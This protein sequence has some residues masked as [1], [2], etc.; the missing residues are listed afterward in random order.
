[1]SVT[2]KT[3][4]ASF[5]R[6]DGSVSQGAI[7]TGVA[8]LELLPDNLYNYFKNNGWSYTIVAGTMHAG[9]YNVTSMSSGSVI[10]AATY[11]DGR[12]QVYVNQNHLA[13]SLLHELG[14]VIDCELGCE[15]CSQEFDEIYQAEKRAYLNIPGANNY[16]ISSYLEYFADAFE[17]Y[18]KYPSQLKKHCPMTYEYIRGIV[19]GL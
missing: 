18:I 14:H 15:S 6:T 2:V 10:Y 1:M 3:K 8:Q 9:D 4:R 17:S 7:D 13:S 5:F 19:T 16:A 11:W 12:D